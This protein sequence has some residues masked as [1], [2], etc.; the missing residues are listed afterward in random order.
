MGI[1]DSVFG[2]KEKS[3]EEKKQLPWIHLESL[4]QLD[5]IV[6]K[7]NGRPQ[8]I[9]KHSMT[10]GISSMTLRMFNDSYE[11][12]A[13]CDLYFL[14][15]Q[16]HREVSDAVSSKLDVRHESP[17]LLILKNGKVSF[18]TSHGAIAEINLKDYL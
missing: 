12:D 4:E 2:K 7:S 10:C 8:V 11:M 17:Q 9:Y 5:E 18:H 1:F 14:T 6:K 15:I 16:S 3:V 13:Q